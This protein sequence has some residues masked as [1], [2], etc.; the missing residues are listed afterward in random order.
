[1]VSCQK[2]WKV[3]HVCCFHKS[4]RSRAGQTYR[5]YDQHRAATH[6]GQSLQQMML[7]TRLQT[8]A[9]RPFVQRPVRC[10]R[11]QR[12]RTAAPAVAAAS[13]A[14]AS[15]QVGVPIK[16]AVDGSLPPCCRSGGFAKECLSRSL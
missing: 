13:G 12:S 1:M 9:S 7:Q 5:T 16:L 6:A 2:L 15:D 11:Q 8:L 14:S 10:S 4:G 3:L